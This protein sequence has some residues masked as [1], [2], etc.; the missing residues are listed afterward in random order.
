MQEEADSLIQGDAKAR[1]DAAAAPLTEVTIYTDGGCE[2]NPGAGGYGAVLVC[3]N[4]T[5]E[6]SGGFQQ[7]TNN[8][9][10]IFAAIAGLEA[11]KTPCRVTLVSDSRYLVDAMAQAWAKR[12]R[13]NGWWRTKKDR[14]VNADLWERLLTLCERHRV[15]FEWVKG[16]AGHEQNERCDALA[17]EALKRPDLPADAGYEPRVDAPAAAEVTREGQSCPACSAPVIKRV[18]R[19]RLKPGQTYYFAYY[20]ECPGCK[21]T[22][23][24][25]EAKRLIEEV[26][27]LF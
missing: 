22:Y 10:E 20:L 21:A 3:G 23:L 14:A 11:L 5:Q 25:E 15:A 19:S 26:P 2:P 9:M 18:P 7:T 6:I 8:R 24:P 27:T 16:H 4:R 1:E 13:A 17:M 12:W